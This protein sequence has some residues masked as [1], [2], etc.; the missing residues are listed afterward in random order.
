[1]RRIGRRPFIVG[2]LL[3]AACGGVAKTAQFPSSDAAF[4]AGLDP[5]VPDPFA[6]DGSRSARIHDCIDR[7]PAAPLRALTGITLDAA[8]LP[9]VY[10]FTTAEQVA[11]LRRGDAV[12]SKTNLDAVHRGHLFDRLAEVLR[13]DHGPYGA[14][15]H[16]IAKELTGPRFELGRFAWPFLAGTRV[17]PERYGDEILSFSFKPEALLV[18]FD[19][20]ETA[21]RFFDA[22]G[23]KINPLVAMKRLDRVA[24]FLFTNLHDSSLETSGPGGCRGELG[25]GLVYRELY[26]GNPAM[27]AEYSLGTPQIV[28]R[29]D[30]EVAD[31]RSLARDL[32]CTRGSIG[33][34]CDVVPYTWDYGGPNR[35][36]KFVASMAFA[37]PFGLFGFAPADLLRLADDL[38]KLRF[39]PSPYVVSL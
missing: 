35:T 10:S 20:R 21:F 28:D 29:I 22:K 27:L 38:E 7:A 24:A 6:V 5:G 12:F 4:D 18:A 16:A 26:L 13:A 36:D 32:D 23:T 25:V 31:L 39:V 9:R 1:M 17:S 14:H 19:T 2:S 15:I 30:A 3:A 34:S 37:S 11:G 33:P 8:D